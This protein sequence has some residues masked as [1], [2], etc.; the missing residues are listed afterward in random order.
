MRFANL[1]YTKVCFGIYGALKM[2]FCYFS[3][4]DFA[5]IRITFL[6]KKKTFW[7]RNVRPLG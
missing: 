3:N 7:D 5:N 2:L 4:F 6:K 1:G